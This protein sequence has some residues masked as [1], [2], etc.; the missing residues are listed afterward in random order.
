MT[1]DRVQR[2]LPEELGVR[3]SEMPFVYNCG[4]HGGGGAFSAFPAKR[5]GIVL[6][7]FVAAE[8]G[9]QPRYPRVVSYSVCGAGSEG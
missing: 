8:P 9:R 3:S 4:S 1:T 6:Y 7:R 5:R 2:W